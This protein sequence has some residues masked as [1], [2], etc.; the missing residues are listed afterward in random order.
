MGELALR[1]GASGLPIFIGLSAIVLALGGSPVLAQD[2]RTNRI[3]IEYVPPKSPEYKSL[4]DSLKANHG[5]EKMQEMFSPF[6]LP[7][8]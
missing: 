4:M 1:C 7:G 6:R 3:Q 8:I 2:A 5:L